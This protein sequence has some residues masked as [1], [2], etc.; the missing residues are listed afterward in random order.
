MIDADIRAA[1]ASFSYP[2]AANEY[3]GTAETYFVFNYSV[4]PV[5]FSDDEPQHEKYLVQLH[6]VA[7]LTSDLAAT[8]KLIRQAIQAAFMYPTETNV[9][10][11]KKQHFV[12][13]FEGVGSAG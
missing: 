3:A 12:F 5:D 1:V 6:L 11:E 7:P 10:D 2:C 13:E 9:S 8:R 4:I